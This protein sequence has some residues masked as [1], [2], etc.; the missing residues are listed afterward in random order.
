M[1][2]TVQLLRRTFT[3]DEYYAMAEA[4]ILSQNDRVELIEGDILRMTPIGSRHAACVLRLSTFFH[5]HLVR[6]ALVSVQ[7]PLRLSRYSEPEPDIALLRPRDDF[8]AEAHPM[9]ADTLLVIEVADSSL[10]YD[11]QVKIP[12][13]ARHGVPE[14]WLVDL[15]RELIEL[16]RTPSPRGYEQMTQAHR[17][18]EITPQSFPDLTLQV[19]ALL[20]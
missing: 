6:R 12:L 11:Q 9:P 16:Y 18:Q 3:V 7:S 8:Y 10:T 1:R 20:G 19:D 17:S 2:M 14:V 5:Q 13:Y 4:G 15:S